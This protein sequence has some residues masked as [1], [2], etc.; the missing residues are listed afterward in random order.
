M[1]EKMESEQKEKKEG[2]R[3]RQRRVALISSR[4]GFE[5]R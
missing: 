3:D 5:T 1:G 2:D 4:P